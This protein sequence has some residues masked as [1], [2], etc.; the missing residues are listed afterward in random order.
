MS[1]PTN[2]PLVKLVE[3]N[4]IP[5]QVSASNST[6]F[7]G[8]LAEQLLPSRLDE[9]DLHG[10]KLNEWN[11]MGHTASQY[12]LRLPNAGGMTARQKKN[13][14]QR[15]DM[16]LKRWRERNGKMNATLRGGASMD[17]VVKTALKLYSLDDFMMNTAG[18]KD[19]QAWNFK[20]EMDQDNTQNYEEADEDAEDEQELYDLPTKL[21][22]VPPWFRKMV[23]M[24][25]R[26]LWLKHHPRVY[27]KVDLDGF[28]AWRAS[29]GATEQLAPLW[30]PT[31]IEPQDR[32]PPTTITSTQVFSAAPPTGNTSNAGPSQYSRAPATPQ[33]EYPDA[34]GSLGPV[35][36]GPNGD[37]EAH[38]HDG[39]GSQDH[40]MAPQLLRSTMQ[41]GFGQVINQE[42]DQANPAQSYLHH[43]AQPAPTTSRQ[44]NTPDPH[45]NEL[46]NTA[47]DNE[48]TSK[49][50][51]EQLEFLKCFFVGNRAIEIDVKLLIR[52]KERAEAIKGRAPRFDAL[53]SM[54]Y[55]PVHISLTHGTTWYNEELGTL[56][57]TGRTVFDPTAFDAPNETEQMMADP[58]QAGNELLA[59]PG[60]S[61]SFG[62]AGET[63]VAHRIVEQDTQAGEGRQMADTT[64]EQVTVSQADGMET[65]LEVDG[66]FADWESFYARWEGGEGRDM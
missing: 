37:A 8:S 46:A 5:R 55:V 29:G 20:P 48:T 43:H 23:D 65:G 47:T 21:Y 33:D 39:E 40:E 2:P 41:P 28:N 31:F 66:P 26:D 34:E 45:T 15:L 58:G 18:E 42:A 61:S 54:G 27:Q 17:K 62:V 56:Q 35:Q 13:V 49:D 36:Y 10:G 25:P 14:Q 53:I 50:F 64:I 12:A 4:P 51:H 30:A 32:A 63:H 9:A 52:A 3:L 1:A 19:V 59:R 57:T 24:P 11:R 60:V 7:Y 16:R 38:G 22:D 6:I 44:A